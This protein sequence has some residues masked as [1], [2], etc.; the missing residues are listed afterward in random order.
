MTEDL[1]KIASPMFVNGR[2]LNDRI[3]VNIKTKL[4]SHLKNFTNMLYV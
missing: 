3:E 4:I 2:Y 1:E